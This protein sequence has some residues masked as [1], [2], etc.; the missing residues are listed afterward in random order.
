MSSQ[1][2]GEILVAATA[3]G[4][5]GTIA[6]VMP[7]RDRIKKRRAA[8]ARAIDREAAATIASMKPV[9]DDVSSTQPIHAVITD[10]PP[11]PPTKITHTAILHP[12]PLKPVWPTTVTRNTQPISVVTAQ[13]LD[14]EWTDSDTDDWIRQMQVK[15][16]EFMIDLMGE[17][18]Y[19][20]A[21]TQVSKAGG[22]KAILG[23]A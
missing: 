20:E 8:R 5:A 10:A 22:P 11:P 16:H 1:E 3:L 17:S 23:R 6:A 4:A 19:I 14:R 13:R 7:F 9:R 12:D 15:M 21:Q 18:D 2:L